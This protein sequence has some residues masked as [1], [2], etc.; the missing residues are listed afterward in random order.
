MRSD[1]TLRGPLA[2]RRASLNPSATPAVSA[3]PPSQAAVLCSA[4]GVASRPLGCRQRGVDCAR[5]GT[6]GGGA[7]F[8]LF[9]RD[10]RSAGKLLE[11]SRDGQVFD[12]SPGLEVDDSC[13]ALASPAWGQAADAGHGPGG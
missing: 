12:V 1:V 4:N 3:A 9:P 7:R 11:R 10:L 8:D 13:F 6:H 5:Y 2:S